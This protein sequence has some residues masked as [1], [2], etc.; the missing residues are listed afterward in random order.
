MYNDL[1]QPWYQNRIT[2]KKI[3]APKTILKTAKGAAEVVFTSLISI[4]IRISDDDAH[5]RS[6]VHF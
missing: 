6:H 3:I 4:I 1:I 5:G 2:L